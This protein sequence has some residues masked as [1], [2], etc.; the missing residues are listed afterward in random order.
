MII[1]VIGM[2][3]IITMII[4]YLE[5]INYRSEDFT[6]DL[7]ITID[8][9]VARYNESVSWLHMKEF[10][11][12][13]RFIIY[14]KGKQITES[15]PDNVFEI[16][17][18][19]VGK[20]DHTFL[21]HI[22]KNY[23]DLADV[24]LFVSGRADDPRK[25]PKILKT[26]D[27]INKTRDSVFIGFYCSIPYDF[28]TF[29]MNSYLSVNPE[30]HIGEG[31]ITYVAPAKIRPFENWF[32]SY[33]NTEKVNIFVYQSIFAVH[34][35]HIIQHPKKYYT[36]FYEELNYDVNPEAGHYMERAWGMIFSPYPKRCKYYY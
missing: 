31:N 10:A 23:D 22:I 26:M 2:I 8:C 29:I 21:Y 14:N 33:W 28:K 35:N 3:I 24:T 12:V 34:K 6:S 36:P 15:M 7:P 27:L 9:V 17:I 1:W 25:G 19:N 18:P 13:N 16:M 20:C 32:K 30:N 4:M 11:N 5:Y